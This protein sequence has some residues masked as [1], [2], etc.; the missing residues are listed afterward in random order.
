M[1]DEGI[2]EYI[3][4]SPDSIE[5]VKAAKSQGWQFKEAE[6]P[7]LRIVVLGEEKNKEINFEKLHLMVQHQE[8]LFYQSKF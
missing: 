8:L 1:N 5:L 2:E 7:D 6:K 3:C 4:V